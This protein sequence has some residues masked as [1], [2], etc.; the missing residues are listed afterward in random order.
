[1]NKQFDLFVK[2][3]IKEEQPV[4]FYETLVLMDTNKSSN[5][6]GLDEETAIKITAHELIENEKT[7]KKKFHL[8]DREHSNKYEDVKNNSELMVSLFNQEPS[9]N[10][11]KF[12]ISEDDKTRIKKPL[13]LAVLST[14]DSIRTRK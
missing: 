2:M 1:M 3:K 5:S 14:F 9:S 7:M 12:E 11:Y 13:I 10:V 4:L 6:P 8:I